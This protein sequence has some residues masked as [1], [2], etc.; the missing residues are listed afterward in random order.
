M[1][2]RLEKG[3]ALAHFRI[4]RLLGAGGMGEVYLA[5]DQRLQRKVALKLLPAS[6]AHD[7]DRIRRFEQE[8]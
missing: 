6:M 8:T 5:E 2:E 7:S 3:A 1:S 4:V